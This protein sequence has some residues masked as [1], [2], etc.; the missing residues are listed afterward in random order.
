MQIETRTYSGQGDVLLGTR[1][2]SGDPGIYRHIGEI[3]PK[4]VS[5]EPKVEQFKVKESS[6]GQRGTLFS[7]TQGRELMVKWAF[8][9]WNPDNLALQVLGETAVI[10]GGTVTARALPTG[11]KAGDI[12]PLG[13]HKV[14][15]L[16]LKDS[17][18]S[19]ATLD[20]THYTLGD[21]AFG[22]VEILSVTGLTQPLKA[23]FEFG[24]ILQIPAMVAQLPEVSILIRLKNTADAGKRLGVELYRVQLNPA[25]TLQL[26]QEKGIQNPEIEGE[27][28]I[29]PTKPA[30]GDLG[31]YGRIVLLDEPTA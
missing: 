2:A 9:T 10:Q 1:L 21:A 30:D 20:D 4:G 23:D 31:Q 11:L 15:S 8:Q 27:V 3:E 25:K 19:P 7:L 5:L 24:S 6:S 13:N 26:I 12:V 17:A 29:D 16:V 18:G 22:L 28:L 14:S